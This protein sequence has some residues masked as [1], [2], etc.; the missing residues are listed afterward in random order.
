MMTYRRQEFPNRCKFACLI[1]SISG[2]NPLVERTFGFLTNLCSEKH[3][4]RVI[5]HL[6][7][8]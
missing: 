1:V 4:Q 8:R 6:W 7:Q 5:N 2:S 3:H